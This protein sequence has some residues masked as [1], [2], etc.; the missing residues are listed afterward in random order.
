MDFEGGF[1]GL[2]EEVGGHFFGGLVSEF[3]SMGFRWRL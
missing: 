2:V 1:G 3:L